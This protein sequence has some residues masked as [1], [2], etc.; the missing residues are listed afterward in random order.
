MRHSALKVQRVVEMSLASHFHHELEEQI[1]CKYLLR[2]KKQKMLLLATA[3]L[4]TS[5]NSKVLYERVDWDMYVDRLMRQSEQRFARKNR[6]QHHSF[7]LLVKLISPHLP[8]HYSSGI[9]GVKPIPPAIQLHCLLRWLAGGC[10]NDICDQMG[11]SAQS[12]YRLIYRCLGAINACPDLALHFPET[13]E[14]I[15]KAAADFES[16]SSHGVIEGCVGC[17][18]GYHLTTRAPFLSETRTAIAHFSGHYRTY[19]VNVQAVCDHKSRFIFIDTGGVGSCSDIRAYHRT[20]LT[21]KVDAL[22]FWKYI[23]ADN[24]YVCSTKLL[25]PFSGSQKNDRSKSDFNYFLSQLRMKI[26]CAFG[27]MT[28]RWRILRSPVLIGV[29]K[30]WNLVQCIARLHNFCIDQKDTATN[31][32]NS[33]Q[34]LERVQSSDP[35]GAGSGRPQKKSNQVRQHIVERIILLGVTRSAANISRNGGY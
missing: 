1:V 29:K 5:R 31:H 25:T 22:P 11:M 24:A 7:V 19:G 3:L 27:M 15:N 13:P 2:K 30:L 26:E 17:L 35:P 16:I 18:D 21:E 6:M 32:F 10:Y 8:M 28:Q 14:E 4:L 23:L 34:G 9:R 12:F 20:A 33:P